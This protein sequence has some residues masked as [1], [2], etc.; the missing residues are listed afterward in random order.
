MTLVAEPPVDLE[1]R[2]Q[3]KQE[4]WH[5]CPAYES[6]FGG[7]KF[8][9]KSL[10]LVMEATRYTWHP[11]YRGIVFRRTYPRLE[12]L[13]DR[14]WQWYPGIGGRA[15]DGG[16]D[17]IF[18]SGAK[19]LFRH[20]QN[21][22]DKRSYHGH[23]YQ[24]MFFDQLEEFS[25]TQYTFLLGQ[26]R[27]G[28]PE[29]V[30][31]TRSTFNPGGIGHGWVK[32]RFIEHGSREC[33]PWVPSN[34]AGDLL[35]P[36]CFHY[37]DMRDNPAGVA[38]D[39]TYR[40]RLGNLSQQ[41]RRALLDGDW[42]VF[43]GQFFTTWRRPKH[44]CEPF[45][46]KPEWTNWRMA[47]DWG[48]GAP[49]SCHFYVRDEDAWSQQRIVRWYAVR[50]LYSKNVS[51]ESQAKQIAEAMRDVGARFKAK[52]G[53]PS[54]WNRL[55]N[56]SSIKDTYA[57]HGVSLSKANNDRIPGWQRLRALLA[58]QA[59]GRPGLIYFSTCPNAIRTIP[60]LIHDQHKVEDLDTDGED[61]A[62]DDARYFA[63]SIDLPLADV[64]LQPSA[65]VQGTAGVIP[66]REP[67]GPKLPDG[68]PELKL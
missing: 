19:V 7:A 30:P 45:A 65:L 47:V 9:G 33:E 8:G 57:R 1:Y 63:M 36:R 58:D 44:V 34:D 37:A 6:G 26:N 15:V 12:E 31:Y 2:P 43:E 25:E 39:P 64:M 35:Q 60:A 54:M 5:A 3:P 66:N 16:K 42:D 38:A 20:C 59:D 13:M 52:L 51:D 28:V 18:P 55:P 67:K 40:Q 21:E 10:G 50:E 11:R 24:G 32:G 23:E 68:W 61:H 29:L 14:A 62:A 49:W 22:D 46:I 48:I 53:D 17:W 56:G 41:E 27:T 4:S